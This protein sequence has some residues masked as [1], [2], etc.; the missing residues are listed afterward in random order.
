MS[1][2]KNVRSPWSNSQ[3][4]VNH[5]T[6]KWFSSCWQRARCQCRLKIAQ[7]YEV[8]IG[9]D[10][11]ISLGISRL[12][13]A[14]LALCSTVF[15][16]AAATTKIHSSRQRQ[17][18][19]KYS[20]DPMPLFDD[21]VHGMK[22]A[23]PAEG[24]LSRHVYHG[25]SPQMALA[26]NIDGVAAVAVSKVDGRIEYIAIRG[27]WRPIAWGAVAAV[28]AVRKLERA[29]TFEFGSL[30]PLD[31]TYGTFDRPAW[32]RLNGELFICVAPSDYGQI[33]VATCVD[34]FVAFIEAVERRLRL[35][36]PRTKRGEGLSL[37]LVVP[38]GNTCPRCDRP[39]AIMAVVCNTCGWTLATERRPRAAESNYPDLLP[40]T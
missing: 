33:A 27:D 37:P 19:P 40:D 34:L 36:I 25:D 26:T 30:P 18:T 20:T 21:L 7:K 14:D 3:F 39:L 10:R 2:G 32:R 31:A 16:N 22:S 13:P 15:R 1:D 6:A 12:L 17:Q 9:V 11:K 38:K 29:C 24:A 8:S 28:G 35:G 23:F 4:E 5:S